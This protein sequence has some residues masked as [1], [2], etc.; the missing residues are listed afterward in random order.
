MTRQLGEGQLS[1]EFRVLLAAA[2]P[3]PMDRWTLT[4]L[5]ILHWD[6]LVE[7]A[8]YHRVGGL[9]YERLSPFRQDVPEAAFA[10][11][12][13][14]RQQTAAVEMAVKCQLSA[15]A[16]AFTASAVSA[17]AMK[18]AALIGTV[19]REAGLRPMID[20]DLLVE[21]Q[22]IDGAVQALEAIRYRPGAV[23]HHLVAYYARGKH[24]HR[25]PLV[26]GKHPMA[27]E[28]HERLTLGI[29]P[30]STDEVFA[31]SVVSGWGAIRLPDPTDL[32]FQVAVHFTEDR[33]AGSRR[34]LAQLADLARTIDRQPVD[35][36]AL[37]LR[38]RSYGL[39]NAVFAALY[40]VSHLGL[41]A[42]P[43]ALLEALRPRS[44]TDALGNRL[45]NER[46]L[47][48]P[49]RP[50]AAAVPSSARLIFLPGRAHMRA[51][52]NLPDASLPRLYLTRA[53]LALRMLT[54]AQLVLNRWLRHAMN[55]PL[56]RTP[57]PAHGT[58][59]H[60][61]RH[62]PLGRRARQLR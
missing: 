3:G 38:S 34:A 27:V 51:R 56:S 5:D 60:T 28:L 18:G 40:V 41:A 42:V 59:R 9:L 50:L 17:I 39:S 8:K 23:P 11:L 36:E 31:R 21:R 46:V 15:I 14:E 26:H 25:V 2:T 37:E 48:G 22:A 24:Q 10:W 4:E 62:L 30:F 44:W 13:S 16:E 54:P 12:R 20:L 33:R 6:Q 29:D 35:W 61:G 1:P 53:R 57:P 47:R 7:L 32:L 55:S 45:V 49:D 58:A 52:Y 43:I 19:Y